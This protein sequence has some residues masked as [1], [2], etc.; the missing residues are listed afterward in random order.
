MLGTAKTVGAYLSI[1]SRRG[2]A[3]FR[4]LLPID[5]D[6]RS[7]LDTNATSAAALN[8]ALNAA[9]R[10]PLRRAEPAGAEGR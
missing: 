6:T 8:A 9:R 4:S 3:L 7:Q 5:S 1:S 10:A 2:V